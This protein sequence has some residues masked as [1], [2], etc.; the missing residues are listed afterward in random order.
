M[1]PYMPIVN[2]YL[3]LHQPK[4][5]LDC[6]AGNG[7]LQKGMDYRSTIHGID[8]YES[9]PENYEKF[10]NQDLDKGINLEDQKYDAV[11]SCEGIEHLGNPLL[12]LTS[13]FGAIKPSGH[14]I[15]TTPNTWH[16]ASKMRYLLNGFFP[17]FPSLVGKV[18]LGTHMHIMPWTFPQ[19]YLY[20][21]LA[22]FSDITIHNINQ[23][24]PKHFYE[25]VFG[26]PQKRY[27]E[28]K[29]KKSRTEEERHYWKQCLSDD[30]LFGRRLAVSARKL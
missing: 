4:K 2:Q 25:K 10:Y 3:N 17:S 24:K 16:P 19:L 15:I 13:A 26:F 1:K 28:R 18:K 6:P 30:S 7:W 22:G 23:E 11:V 14:I 27:C 9:K 29:L 21:S 5:I 8:L 12:F 20:L